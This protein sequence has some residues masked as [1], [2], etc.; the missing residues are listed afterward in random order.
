MSTE[1]YLVVIERG[2]RNCSAYSPDVPGCIATGA[3]VEQTVNRM[4]RALRDHLA[5]LAQ[6][7]EPLPAARGLAWHLRHS[8]DFKPAPGDLFTQ[9]VVE[10]VRGEPA[11]A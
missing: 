9:V 7:D 11:A 6:D 10:T 8:K 4:R 1:N 5:G 2:T 3:T